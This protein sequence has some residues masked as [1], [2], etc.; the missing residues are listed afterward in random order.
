MTEEATR[1]EG[2]GAL[3]LRNT[4]V[5]DL[6]TGWRAK[7]LAEMGTWE[8]EQVCDLVMNLAL[9]MSAGSQKCL[10]HAPHF[11]AETGAILR[12]LVTHCTQ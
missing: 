11:L 7:P 12:N 1:G 9:D 5:S 2:K 8:P 3:T 4:Q 6:V 10:G